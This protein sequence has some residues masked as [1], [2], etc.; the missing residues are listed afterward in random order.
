MIDFRYHIVSIAA[1]FLALALGLVLGST[2]G[3][4]N[5]AI[6]DLDRNIS[7]LRNT[8]NGLRDSVDRER[9]LV[10]KGDELITVLLPE[11]VSGTLKGEQVAVVSAPGSSGSVRDAAEETLTT[12]G[13]TIASEVDLSDAFF[14]SDNAA[15]LAGLVDR[16]APSA[17]TDGPALDRAAAALGEALLADTRAAAGSELGSS[18][19]AL[20]AG[21]EA[22]K[23][24]KVSDN[25]LRADLVVLVAA[26]PRDSATPQLNGLVTVVRVLDEHDRG[27]V[28]IGQESPGTPSNGLVHS[29]RAD[30]TTADSVSSVDDA[31][32]PAGD[33]RLVRALQAELLGVVGHYGTGDGAQ[34]VVATATPSP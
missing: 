23:L 21:F 32:T 20:V 30:K 22:A 24:L 13:A 4:Q 25:P 14:T 27:T 12:A 19:T 1:V 29:L 17:P 33:L 26:P 34:A 8:N 15:V 3:F 10:R 7:K 28:V 31:D 2:S 18:A 6:S 16:L 11:L 5:K 9:G